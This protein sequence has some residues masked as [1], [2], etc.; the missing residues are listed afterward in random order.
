MLLKSSLVLVFERLLQVNSIPIH[1]GEFYFYCFSH[2][3][4]IRKEA[5]FVTY[6]GFSAKADKSKSP[7]IL[8][9]IYLLLTF[10]VNKH[11]KV[12]K[13]TMV[14]LVEIKL[15]H[16]ALHLGMVVTQLSLPPC[17][18]SLL[19]TVTQSAPPLAAGQRRA[20]CRYQ[21]LPP[22]SSFGNAGI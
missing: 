7:I 17:H 21:V 6:W 9:R 11:S 20:I 14:L 18:H 10:V 4:A 15:A 2:I 12:L 22:T 3:T 13:I 5:E 19:V 1:M 8:T 16:S